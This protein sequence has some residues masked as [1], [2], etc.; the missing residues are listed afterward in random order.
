MRWNRENMR[1]APRRSSRYGL[2]CGESLCALF[3]AA[4]TAPGH[5]CGGSIRVLGTIADSETG[6]PIA[7]APVGVALFLQGETILAVEPLNSMEQPYA[8]SDENGGFLIFASLGLVPCR[9]TGFPRP[10]QVE[11]IVVRDDCEQ[12][13]MIEISENTAQFVEVEFSGKV[14]LELKN[15]ILVPPCEQAP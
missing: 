3:F 11:I 5:D 6:V 14:V 1:L 4:C 15:L 8:P 7:N 9:L 2:L 10:D 12:R 13:V